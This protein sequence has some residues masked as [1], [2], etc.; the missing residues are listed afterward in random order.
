MYS[1]TEEARENLV[2]FINHGLH[3]KVDFVFIM[4]GETNASALLPDK[5]NIK[6][7]MRDNSCYDLGS[8][9]EVLL[10]DDLWLQY[11]RYILMNASVR[12]PFVPHWADACWSERLLSKV[13]NEVKVSDSQ[14]PYVATS[15]SV[16][17]EPVTTCS[18][19]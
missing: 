6:V 18:G 7:V 1:E 4:N 11:K 12:G 15:T 9:A 19:Q 14:I 16:A 5:P 10:K 17:S 2:F 13:T 3:A 8:H